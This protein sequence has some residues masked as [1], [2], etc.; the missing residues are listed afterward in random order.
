MWDSRAHRESQWRYDDDH[1]TAARAHSSRDVT[2]ASRT[3][4]LVGVVT[5]N[6]PVAPVTVE[7]V[8]AFGQV[9]AASPMLPGASVVTYVPLAGG[10]YSV[11][12]RN[13]GFTPVRFSTTIITR[14]ASL[15]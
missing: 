15:F 7:I 2:T 8:N 1:D 4:L 11:R 14:E 3:V 12:A 13:N 9:V 10:T 6:D 5:A